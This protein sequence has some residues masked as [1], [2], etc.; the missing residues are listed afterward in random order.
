MQRGSF[1]GTELLSFSPDKIRS[2]MAEGA[3]KPLLDDD[4]EERHNHGAA[5]TQDSE[6]ELMKLV[7]G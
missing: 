3:S 7:R 1:V 2:K 4:G 6:R 5:G